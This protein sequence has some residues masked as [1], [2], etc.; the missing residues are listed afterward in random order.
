MSVGR[1]ARV[2]ILDGLMMDC[3]LEWEAEGALRSG[4]LFI[5]L[6][7]LCEHLPQISIAHGTDG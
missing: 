3:L 1:V 7:L 4:Q 2:K 5:C 6:C